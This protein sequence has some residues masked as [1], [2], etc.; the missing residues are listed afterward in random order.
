MKG[1]ILKDI[2]EI[3]FQIIM[4]LLI[5]LWP[6][7]CLQIGFFSMVGT[8]VQQLD[9]LFNSML[10]VFISYATIVPFTSLLLN[11]MNSDTTSGWAKI[12]RTMP[13][14]SGQI[15][16]SKLISTAVMIAVFVLVSFIFNLVSFLRSPDSFIAELLLISP[17]CIGIMQMIT[18][19]PVFPLSMKI[20]V[21]KSNAIYLTILI[22]TAIAATILMFAFFSEDLSLTAAKIIIFA[23]L[24]AACI[25]TITASYYLSR[26]LIAKDL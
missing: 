13:V 24:P 12:Q 21:K 1:L 4:G 18:L 22:L 6:N 14:S 15:V 8:G 20:G 5:G 3:R 23:G 2:Y 11:T 26:N 25:I 17:F 16:S 7:V 10:L 19:T 9:S